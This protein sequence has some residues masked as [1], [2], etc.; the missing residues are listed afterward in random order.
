LRDI[1]IE[2]ESQK[3]TKQLIAQSV[4]ASYKQQMIHFKWELSKMFSF[5]EDREPKEK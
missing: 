5:P 4:E 1:D 3:F 2:A